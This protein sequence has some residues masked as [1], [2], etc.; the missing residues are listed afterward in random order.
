MP[1]DPRFRDFD[2]AAS[3]RSAK[4]IPIRVCGKTWQLPVTAPAKAVLRIQR[5]MVTAAEVEQSVK[6][7]Q[8]PDADQLAQI[9]DEDWSIEQ[10]VRDLVGDKLVDGWL[11]AGIDYPTLAEVASYCFA[12]YSNP[13]AAQPAGKAPAD[14]K[15]PAAKKQAAR[16]STR[17]R[18]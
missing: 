10:M 1:T 11:D 15:R 9:V 16:G 2:A 7:G 8:T 13:D 14:R 3:E 17:P 12:V 5:L 18:S 4:P 6:D